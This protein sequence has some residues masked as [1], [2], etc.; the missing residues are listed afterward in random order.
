MA[1]NAKAYSQPDAACSPW[2]RQSQ[3]DQGDQA[4]YTRV[5]DHPGITSPSYAQGDFTLFM[6]TTDLTAQAGEQTGSVGRSG[7]CDHSDRGSSYQHCMPNDAGS[8]KCIASNCD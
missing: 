6:L 2:R 3:T 4:E 5:G 1:H 7:P 8:E